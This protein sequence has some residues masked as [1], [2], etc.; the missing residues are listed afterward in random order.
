[1]LDEAIPH[2]PLEAEFARQLDKQKQEINELKRII[3]TCVCHAIPGP[4]IVVAD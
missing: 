3:N 2:T 4:N 1:M